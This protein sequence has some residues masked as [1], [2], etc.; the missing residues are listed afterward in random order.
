MKVLLKRVRTLVVFITVL[1]LSFGS[2]ALAAHGEGS[3]PPEGEGSGDHGRKKDSEDQG[4]LL[5]LIYGDQWIIVRDVSAEGDGKPVY[6]TWTWPNEA[7]NSEGDFEPNPDN[8]S[9]YNIEVAVTNEPG[10][11]QPVSFEEV[12]GLSVQFEVNT[13]GVPYYDSY[14]RIKSPTYLIPLD[15]ECKIPATLEELW[16]ELVMEA[17]AGRFNLSRSPQDVLDA[18]YEEA[19]VTINSASDIS[20]DPAGRLLLEIP[21]VDEYGEIIDNTSKTIDSPLQNLA[22]YQ[23]IMLEGCLTDTENVT[24]NDGAKLLLETS[25]LAYL[26]CGTDASLTGEDMQRAASF[27]AGAGDKTGRITLDL[28]VYLNNLLEINQVIWAENKQEIID[29]FYYDFQNFIYDRCAEHASTTADLLQPLYNGGNY[30][31]MFQIVHGV[32]IFDKRFG[33][34]WPQGEC[35]IGTNS[36]YPYDDVDAN[37]PIIN[38]V[39]AADDALTIIDYIHNYE[40]PAYPLEPVSEVNQ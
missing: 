24:L 6:I 25:D 39:R 16:G 26:S 29:I 22:L 20:L 8:L 21:V 2:E 33:Y 3:G 12:P 40:L 37:T 28:L 38:F 34:N 7:Y 17:D 27:L 11:V 36:Y 13:L 35:L 9:S 32:T 30:P 5:G 19:L 15:P 23:N 31:N 14:G 4:T 18:S 10:C 1:L